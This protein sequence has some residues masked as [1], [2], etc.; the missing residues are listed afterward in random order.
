MKRSNWK[1]VSAM[2]LSATLAFA[3]QAGAPAF[4]PSSTFLQFN[5]T[6][7]GG[8]VKSLDSLVPLTIT[9]TGTAT[10]NITSATISNPEFSLS[11]VSVALPASVPPSG[12]TQPFVV[13]F[14]PSGP[15]MR[16]GDLVLQDD[17]A[18]SP[19][20]IQLIGFGVDVAAGDFALVP[21]A[22]NIHL[23]TLSLPAGATATYDLSVTGGPNTISLSC[24]GAPPEGSCSVLP[25]VSLDTASVLGS[26]STVPIRVTV[27]TSAPTATLRGVH[28][29]FWW[30]FAGAAG[31]ALIAGRK[32][33]AR[34]AVLMLCAAAM[35][36]GIATCGS[37]GNPGTPAGSYTITVTATGNGGIVHSI[38]LTLNLRPFGTP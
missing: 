8:L 12:T 35:M 31:L 30:T 32:R 3:V 13:V 23:L 16:T 9:N 37:G 33:G 38:P 1:L 25:S 24:S 21:P 11:P 34:L 26:D 20:T 19:H 17:A 2:V 10:L 27:A 6:M 15:G 28:P 14:S 4:Q 5:P 29:G 7:V 36:S 18:G 22:N